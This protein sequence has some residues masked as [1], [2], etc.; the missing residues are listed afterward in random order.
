ME[1]EVQCSHVF[2]M[3]IGEEYLL[4]TGLI[5]ALCYNLERV[6]SEAL[7]TVFAGGGYFFLWY[8]ARLEQLL[9][10][11]FFVLLGCPFT[12]PLARESRF[13]LA[14]ICTWYFWVVIFS[15]NQYRIYEAIRK[16]RELTLYCSFVLQIFL[17][18]LLLS[19]PPSSYVCFIYHVQDF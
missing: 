10:K 14:F 16:S 19:L 8:L 15:S 17:T 6:E 9:H 4:T 5:G 13:S 7:Q 2:S 3:H 18:I 12:G 1:V 11:N